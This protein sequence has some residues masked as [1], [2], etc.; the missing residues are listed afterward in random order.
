MIS[1]LV[2]I[3]HIVG[4]VVTLVVFGHLVVGILQSLQERNHKRVL[5][6]IATTLGLPMSALEKKVNRPKYV[7]VASER[8]SN[9]LLRN[10]LSDLCGVMLTL[11]VLIGALIQ[12]GIVGYTIWLL[13]TEGPSIGLFPWVAVGVAIFFWL[14]SMI[15]LFACYILTGRFPGEARA[16]RE[17]WAYPRP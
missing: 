16:S 6:E 1:V 2:A 13:F 5:Q 8:Y 15:L 9:E 10:R 11:W 7:Q 12:W 14:A 3:F 17:A 4:T